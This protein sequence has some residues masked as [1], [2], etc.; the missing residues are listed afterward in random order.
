MDNASSLKDTTSLLIE[1][2]CK[3]KKYNETNGRGWEY[4][5]IATENARLLANGAC[6]GPD[7]RGYVVPEKGITKVYSTI[8]DQKVRAVDGKEG[9]LS[10][11]FTLVM[12][13]LDPNIKTNFSSDDQA[14]GGI[15]LEKTQLELIWE[16]DLYIYNRR[17]FKS[18]DEW[19]STKTLN[20]LTSNEVAQ[21]D[22]TDTTE[23]QN[24]KTAVEWR[25]EIKST[26]YCNFDHASYPMD[27]QICNLTFGSSSFGAIFVLHDPN[28]IYHGE[29]IYYEAANFDMSFTFFDENL[30][31]GRS[32]VG[33]RI[34]MDRLVSS[35]IMKY[36][37]PCI[38]I[39]LVSGL[40]FAIPQ[41]AIPGRIALLV[42]QF[43][44]L[45]NLS[46]YQMVCKS[47]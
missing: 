46:I 34:E 33:L 11:D 5:W 20:I 37:L 36:Y 28:N 29:H 40:S 17:S 26:I 39:V 41:T 19:R 35:F 45:I 27:K 3:T 23:K 9:T 16:P 32:T 18:L 24:S 43:L 22:S 10:I 12:R 38:A 14:N 31:N 6:V 21:I 4:E 15:V 47:F 7:Y 30:N 13:W 42:T 8:E 2:G 25:I 44:T 1:A